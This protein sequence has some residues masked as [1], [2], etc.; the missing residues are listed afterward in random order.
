MEDQFE[1]DGPWIECWQCSG[2]GY[3]SNCFEEYACVDPEG[4]CDEC[5][6]KCDICK[7]KGGWP[8]EEEPTPKEQ[9][10]V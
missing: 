7:G 9:P 1:Y 3:V 2:D 8:D 4:G 10:D 5:T 6:R